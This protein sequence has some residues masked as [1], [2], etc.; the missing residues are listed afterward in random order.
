MGLLPNTATAEIL[1]FLPIWPE[2]F[3]ANITTFPQ[4]FSSQ[5]A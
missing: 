5:I 3:F 1:I 4:K 2:N